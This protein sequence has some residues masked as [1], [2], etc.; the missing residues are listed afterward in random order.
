MVAYAFETITAEQAAAIRLGD[1]LTIN[2]GPARAVSVVYQ[3]YDPAA[4]T[5]EVPHILITAGGR[6]VSF[7]TGIVQLSDVGAIV[8]ADG[9][10]LAIG[11]TSSERINGGTGSD[12]LYGGPGD[13]SLAG[14]AGDDMLHGNTGDDTL[15]GGE[16]FDVL[17]GGQ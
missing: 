6:T 4:L 9:S 8:V 3:S 5:P 1:T 16:G 10:T 2:A 11:D 14:G 13:D 15:T 17:Y 12:G 7:G